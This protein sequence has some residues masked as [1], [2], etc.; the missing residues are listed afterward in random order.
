V[1]ISVVTCV[2]D[3]NP[4]LFLE[5]AKSVLEQSGEVEWLVVDDGSRPQA[6]AAQEKIV[7]DV[8]KRI[9]ARYVPLNKNMGLS[10]ARNAGLREVCGEWVVIL[11]SDDRLSPSLFSAIRALPGRCLVA[12]FDTVFFSES[13]SEYRSVAPFAR[14]FKRHARSSLDPFLWWD[15]YYQGLIARR[16]VFEH[17]EGYRDCLVVGEDQDILLRATELCDANEVAFIPHIGY[18]YR[19]NPDGVCATRWD[20]VVG[21]YAKTMVHGAQQRGAPFIACRFGGVDRIGNAQTDCY[22][23]QTADGQWL[24]WGGW[25]SRP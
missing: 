6:R 15:F 4:M 13:K 9:T 7:R 18:Y 16:T 12:S 2:R 3:Q 17:T 14:L 8:S 10:A 22:E 19:N 20:E 11:D 21:N 25:R 5:C 24:T 23:Y 1:M